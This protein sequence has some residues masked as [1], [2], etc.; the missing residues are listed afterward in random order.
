MGDRRRFLT[1]AGMART[2]ASFP[3]VVDV[4]IHSHRRHIGNAPSQPRSVTMERRLAAALLEG[5]AATS[6]A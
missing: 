2:A 3:Q 6:P 1:Q 5:L 4:V